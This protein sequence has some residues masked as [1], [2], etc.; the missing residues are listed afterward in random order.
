MVGGQLCGRHFLLP[1]PELLHPELQG[2]GPQEGRE[3]SH[4]ERIKKEQEQEEDGDHFEVER[5][6]NKCEPIIINFTHN[7][8]TR[9]E[10]NPL[11]IIFRLF[12]SK[13]K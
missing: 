9:E 2:G 13:N 7:K 5:R 6:M 12:S 11:K 1:L 10:E 4:K 3:E 8:E